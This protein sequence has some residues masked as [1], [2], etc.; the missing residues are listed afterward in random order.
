MGQP[1]FSAAVALASEQQVF[2]AEYV[3]AIT[4]APQEVS[5]ASPGLPEALGRQVAAQPDQTEVERDLAQYEQYVA[6]RQALGVAV[7]GAA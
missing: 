7:G 6:N 5:T 2:G 3:Q 1:E 4:Q